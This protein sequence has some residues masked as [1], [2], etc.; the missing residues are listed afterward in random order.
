MFQPCAPPGQDAIALAIAESL[1]DQA[2]REQRVAAM[3]AEMARAM[4]ASLK[5]QKHKKLRQQQDQETLNK[6]IAASLA[7]QD[8]E[9]LRQQQDQKALNEAIAASRKLIPNKKQKFY[10]CMGHIYVCLLRS[11]GLPVEVGSVDGKPPLTD[12]LL[13]GLSNACW[14][15]SLLGAALEMFSEDELLKNPCLN[16]LGP[17]KQK[18]DSHNLPTALIASFV[19]HAMEKGYTRIVATD[20]TRHFTLVSDEN[21][22]LMVKEFF[23][24]DLV[25]NIYR[26]GELVFALGDEKKKC[27]KMRFTLYDER[28]TGHYQY[29]SKAG[30]FAIPRIA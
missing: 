26:D 8:Q 19:L 25:V 23:D 29:H 18:F 2:A 24:L 5:D 4:K 7:A 1:K 6:A 11:L 22:T 20:G 15:I 3:N 10:T 13:G 28:G 17:Q 16:I 12:V 21:L 30:I 9:K 14:A 27:M